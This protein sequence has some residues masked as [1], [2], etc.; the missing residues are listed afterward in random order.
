MA[1]ITGAFGSA[2]N[3]SID[4]IKRFIVPMFIGMVIIG[5]IVALLP[6]TRKFL[7]AGN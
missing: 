5:I 2:M 6:V 1:N 4:L 7:V 3:S